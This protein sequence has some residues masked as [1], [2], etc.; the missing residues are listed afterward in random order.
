[1]T[2]KLNQ[3]LR[4]QKKTRQTRPLLILLLREKLIHLTRAQHR[5]FLE[6]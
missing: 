2:M 3:R 6:T 4:V 5:Q 1:M